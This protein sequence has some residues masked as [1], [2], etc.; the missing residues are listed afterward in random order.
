MKQ[1]K[2]IFLNTPDL[3]EEYILV[4][5]Y[6]VE[7]IEEEKTFNPLVYGI[8]MLYDPVQ[9]IEEKT[10][11]V[12]RLYIYDKNKYRNFKLH[13]YSEIAAISA[14]QVTSLYYDPECILGYMTK[15]YFE[16]FNGGYD[17]ERYYFNEYQKIYER[18]LVFFEDKIGYA[19]HD[20][21]RDY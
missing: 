3:P 21:R 15:A 17:T 7:N 5:R 10:Y 9:D 2:R 16:I 14:S 18:F 4:C 8:A 1:A 19:R 20:L 13:D 11:D 12:W 6:I